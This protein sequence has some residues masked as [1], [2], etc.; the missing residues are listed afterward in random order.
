MDQSLRAGTVRD[1]LDEIKQEWDQA[2]RDVKQAE[3]ISDNIIIPAIKELR[4][5]G[6]RLID[7]LAIICGIDSAD[8][9]DAS[10]LIDLLRDARFDCHRARHDAIDAATS[11]MTTDLELAL[12]K[13]GPEVVLQCFHNFQAF[14]VALETVRN[15]IVQSRGDRSN[16]EKVYAAIENVN[17]P[18]L[19]RYHKELKESDGMMRSIIIARRKER[20]RNQIFG[21]AGIAA[22]VLS[23][24]IWAYPHLL[25]G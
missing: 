13:L 2:E 10:R 23:V 11:Q 15:N 5:A 22:V 16:R 20:F 4:Y 12:E 9:N 17:F 18:E 6:R 19:V 8:Q 1:L 3:Q 21:Y 24:I 25:G 7:V 14:R